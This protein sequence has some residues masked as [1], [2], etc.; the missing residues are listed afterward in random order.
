MFSGRAPEEWQNIG[1]VDHV[2]PNDKEKLLAWH[3]PQNLPEFSIRHFE[4]HTR[5]FVKVQDGCDSF[6]TY[7]ITSRTSGAGPDRGGWTIY[8]RNPRLGRN[9]YKEVVLTGINV[10]D[11]DG[12]PARGRKS[13]T[14]GGLVRAVDPI[15][16]VERLRVSSID[17]DEVDDDLADAVFNGKTTCPS[18]H[19]VLQSGSNVI[20][21]RMNRKYT[22]Q[23]FFGYRSRLKT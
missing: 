2:V 11:F 10:G 23:I 3:F 17:P 8:L 16:G 5:A 7:C 9:G 4:A 22:R 20:L 6:C 19:L 15:E 14:S 13:K 12:A 18:L 21:K 1:G